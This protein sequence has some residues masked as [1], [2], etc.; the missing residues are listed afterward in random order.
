MEAV[1]KVPRASESLNRVQKAIKSKNPSLKKLFNMNNYTPLSNN[2]NNSQKIVDQN[3][4][5]E[6]PNTD[7]NSTGF[8]INP[9]PPAPSSASNESI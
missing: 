4:I 2:N 1:T 9:A 8:Y 6:N 3:N 7:Q 5:F